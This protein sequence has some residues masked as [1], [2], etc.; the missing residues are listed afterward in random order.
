MMGGEQAVLR[1]SSGQ[2]DKAVDD[3]VEGERRHHDAHLHGRPAV[4]YIG[5]DDGSS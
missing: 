2:C 4:Q 5:K 1:A 3:C